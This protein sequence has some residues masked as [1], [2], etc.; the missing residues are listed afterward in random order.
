MK[1]DEAE[2]TDVP[3]SDEE[4]MSDLYLHFF[5]M[6]VLYPEGERTEDVLRKQKIRLQEQ[7]ELIDLAQDI[8]MVL[9]MDFRINFWNH[10]A[11]KK[12][13]WPRSQVIGQITHDLLKTEFPRPVEEIY[14]ELIERGFWS[15]ELRQKTRNDTSIIVDSRWSLRR[16][17]EGN[18]TAVLQINNDITQRKQAE[19]LL[20]KTL[21]ELENRVRKRT[22]D[23]TRLNAELAQE[24]EE[25]RRMEEILK[26][27]EKELEVK[28]RNLEELNTA[29]TVL[30]KKREEDKNQLEERV[31]TNVKEMVL[32]YTEKLR[33]TAL[34][35]DQAAYLSILENHLNDIISPFLVKMSAKYRRFTPKEIQ[36]ATLVKD[37]KTSKE[38]ADIM[39]VCVGAVELHRNHIRKKLGLT[40]K[41][42][43]LRSYL[44]SLP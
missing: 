31:L 27:R 4:D 28:S 42:M 35:S 12:Y 26:K 16:D 21:Q 11:E 36:V 18:P 9:D 38:I 39:N 15:G 3:V 24:V 17:L 25:R 2:K 23:L 8:I 30:L 32:P 6:A 34:H 43:N 20:Q 1:N 41:K 14:A 22:A 44:L 10:G 5:E 29:L 37:G 33:N 7:S 40:H 19:E 13:G